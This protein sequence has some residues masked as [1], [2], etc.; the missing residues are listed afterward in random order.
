[1][2][3]RC[4]EE[5]RSPVGESDGGY[6]IDCLT[7]AAEISGRL[8]ALGP[9]SR[10]PDFR[11]VRREYSGRLRAAPAADV[12]ELARVLIGRHGRRGV[13]LE[14]LHYHRAAFASLTPALVEELGQGMASWGATDH[15]GAYVAGPAWHAGM[16]GDEV[17]HR[18]ARCADRWWR[19]AA[20][21]SCIYPRGKVSKTLA[22][23]RMLAADKDDTVVKAV[24]WA[25]RALVPCDR[26]AVERFLA[27]HDCV[28]AARIKREV[29]HKLDTGLKNPRRAAA[30]K[31]KSRG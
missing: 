3:W 17:I 18:W 27:E 8:E 9:D 15:F 29:R 6:G 10:V 2:R 4:S 14:L 26:G 31:E 11:A 25:L 28:L 20:L 16:I 13:A 12:I 19:R 7:V 30:G 24:S 23:S 21:V 1:M 22:V 5:A